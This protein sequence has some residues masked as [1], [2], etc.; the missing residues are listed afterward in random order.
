M[1][2]GELVAEQLHRGGEKLPRIGLGQLRQL[3]TPHFPWLAPDPLIGLAGVGVVAEGDKLL[4]IAQQLNFLI[5]YRLQNT[6]AHAMTGRGIALR[7]DK[8]RGDLLEGRIGAERDRELGC[9]ADADQHLAAPLEVFPYQRLDRLGGLRIVDVN[10]ERR[11]QARDEACALVPTP[12]LDLGVGDGGLLLPLFGHWLLACDG[13]RR[14]AR[15]A[16]T[17]SLFR[18][19]LARGFTRVSIFVI[20]AAPSV[21]ILMRGL[22]VA[23]AEAVFVQH[24]RA[25]RTCEFLEVRCLEGLGC[26]FLLLGLLHVP[27]VSVGSCELFQVAQAPAIELRPSPVSG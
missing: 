1:R 15:T 7:R 21:T 16:E 11:R 23:S 19:H 13:N 20:R 14:K 27:S 4:A 8:V 5:V 26:S 25:L 22:G 18:E 9:V 3:I 12:G 17:L 24:K 10:V 6:T 2:V